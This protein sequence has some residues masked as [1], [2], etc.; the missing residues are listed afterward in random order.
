MVFD[1][2]SD[3]LLAN[4]DTV[5]LFDPKLASWHQVVVHAPGR[6][7]GGNRFSVIDIPVDS[8]DAVQAWRD[9]IAT[10]RQS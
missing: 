10:A 3:A 1:N 4:A 7:R 2:P 5:A 8:T 9:R 6:P